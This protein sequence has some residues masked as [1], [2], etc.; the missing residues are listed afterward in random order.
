MKITDGE[1]SGHWIPEQLDLRPQ[2]ERA[3]TCDVMENI[4]DYN[5]FANYI[6]LFSLFMERKTFLLT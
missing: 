4:K 5:F 1:V 2:G 6:Y 3:G